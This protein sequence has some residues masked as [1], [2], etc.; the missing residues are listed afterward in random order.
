M[1]L[2]DTH[3]VIRSCS[4]Q[5]RIHLLS[6]VAVVERPDMGRQTIV[7]LTISMASACHK[8]LKDTLRNAAPRHIMRPPKSNKI[9]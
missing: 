1:L 7:E 2:S 3:Q 9:P 8:S 5:V 6:N 4:Q